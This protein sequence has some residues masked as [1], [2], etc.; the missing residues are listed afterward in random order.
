M[1][2]SFLDVLR[3]PKSRKPLSVHVFETRRASIDEE[4][5]ITEGLL[6]TDDS[7]NAYPIVEGV[8]V[9]LDGSFTQQFLQKH[10]DR[11]SR[12]ETLAKLN[13]SKQDTLDWS[14]SSE[15]DYHFDSDLVRT[16]GWTV[17]ERVQQFLL[18][19][20]LDRSACEG[21]LIL[22]AGCGNGQLSEALTSLGAEVVAL[23]Y[24]TSVAVAERRRKASNVHFVR[25]DLQSPPFDHN[26]FDIVISNGVL[27][28]T[29]NTYRAFAEVAKLVKPGGRFYLWLYRKPEKFLRRC[30]MY[31]TLDLVRIIT[32]RLP[33]GH[34][35]LVVKGFALALLSL[36][37]LLGKHKDGSLSWSERVVSAYD[38]LTPRWRHYHTP[39]EVSSW[40]FMN[41]YS[42]P[43][44]THWDNPYGFGM[45]ATKKPQQ[46]T[47]GMNFGRRDIA[48]RYWR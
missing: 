45:V 11:I 14:F 4:E 33:R 38:G 7:S 43:T 15:W 46:D 13:L 8:P 36:H 23:D 24:S 16:W 40:F 17:D 5:D 41:G 48:K 44:I 21:K 27:H 18:E 3:A 19:T 30:V 9:L 35:M 42:C 6:L 29:P 31:P 28:H 10:S 22:D 47:P 25:G 37:A 26:T 32:S 39:L 12:N 1:R 34:Q 20:D 2:R